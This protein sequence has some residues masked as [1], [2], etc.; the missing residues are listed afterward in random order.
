MVARTIVR[1]REKGVKTVKL[2]LQR[3]GANVTPDQ[4]YAGMLAEIGQELGISAELFQHW[5]ANQAVGPLARWIGALLEVVLAKREA[6][7]VVFIDE[8]DFVRALPF[9]TDEFFAGIRDCYNRRS[10]GSGF[11]H[12]TFCLVGVATPG[13]LIRNPEVTPFNIGT[14]IDISDFS[15]QELQ[16]YATVLDEGSRN[17]AQL[18]TRVHHWLNGHPYLTQLL[19]SHIALD[20]TVR[21][22]HDV[23]RLVVRLFMSP[24][25]RQREPNFADVERR[26]LEPDVPG[27]SVEE[28]RTQVLELYGKVLKGKPIEAAEENPVVATLRL[29]GVGLEDRRALRVR[30]RLYAVVFDEKWRR[31]SLPDA[32]RRRQRGAARVAVLRTATAAAVALFAVSAGAISMWQLSNS[33]AKTLGDLN[34]RTRELLTI[35]S[36]RKDALEKLQVQNQDLAKLS[37][38][39][40]EALGKLKKSTRAV[41]NALA[42]RQATVAKLRSNTL[43]LERSSR[44]RERAIKSLG[45][46]NHQLSTLGYVGLMSTIRLA[47]GEER[48]MRVAEQ[49]KKASLSPHRGWE[50]GHLALILGRPLK[51]IDF[52]MN[53]LFSA[54]IL[55]VGDKL[56][57]YTY[58]GVYA[59]TPNGLQLAR[60]F[61]DPASKYVGFGNTPSIA[62]DEDTGQYVWRHPETRQIVQRI[63]GSFRNYHADWNQQFMLVG[64]IGFK[65][66]PFELRSLD[67]KKTLA[68]FTWDGNPIAAAMFPNG[69]FLT[70][71]K[72]GL[73][74]RRTRDGKVL[75]K[76]QIE[77]VLNTLEIIFWRSRDGN[78]FVFGDRALRQRQVMRTDDLSVVSTLEGPALQSPCVNFSP[79]G[80]TLLVGGTDGVIRLHDIRTGAILRSYV[81]HTSSVQSLRFAPNGKW[82]A[83]FDSKSQLKIW[84]VDQAEATETIYNPADP[85]RVAWTSEDGKHLLAVKKSGAFWVLNRKTGE[86]WR[87]VDPGRDLYDP[88]TVLKSN[89]YFAMKGGTVE[90]C[91]I[92][93]L[94]VILSRKV[95]D[96]ELES[97]Y[98]ADSSTLLAS[99]STNAAVTKFALL[100]G[101]TLRVKRRF[102]VKWPEAEKALHIWSSDY[103]KGRWFAFPG[104]SL[105]KTIVGSFNGFVVLLN[106]DEGVVRTIRLQTPLFG[107]SISGESNTLAI[108]T[109]HVI[110]RRSTKITLYDLETGKEIGI[111]PCPND[112]LSSITF[113]KGGKILVA[114][115][116]DRRVHVWDVPSRKLKATLSP[117]TPIVSCSF[118]PDGKR[119]LTG[120]LNRKTTL[121][122]TETAEEL[123]TLSYKP[124]SNGARGNVGLGYDIGGFSEDGTEIILNCADG[125]VRI[126]KSLLQKPKD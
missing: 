23:D 77:N 104:N 90:K 37:K 73:M 79:Q 7:I 43:E 11:Q 5:S 19:C 108:A 1:L 61:T 66:S 52:P 56:V 36:E 25:A 106:L 44:E 93:G 117:G 103:P 96:E 113:Q 82:F 40:E 58:E 76:T 41:E 17:G 48:W 3:I 57:L 38:Q 15:L 114:M 109:G 121:W 55:T 20:K 69:D 101:E 12:L 46:S 10:E 84:N 13:Q 59:V 6:P 18:L 9:P 74:T 64:W 81:A 102:Q 30:N 24:E 28:K 51:E 80:K 22:S 111:L 47:M 2:D 98:V 119:I 60:R 83:S 112:R 53:S 116:T 115:T 107:A 33:R 50:Y 29:S 54:D 97:V 105:L 100:D 71:D 75:A 94:R 42:S 87:K 125:A 95:M 39:R 92:E 67:G 65:N 26:I 120:A 31:Q 118:S 45:A 91:S 124:L 123:F 21:S 35:S 34:T 4:W 86:Q 126:F 78:Y 110:G 70:L 49:M 32:E 89:I 99:T 16:A 85:H 68:T 122:D 8:V 63:G 72:S 27:L 14:R 62:V 88:S